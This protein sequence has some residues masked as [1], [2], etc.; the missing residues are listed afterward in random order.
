MDLVLEQRE[1]RMAIV[2]GALR[3]RSNSLFSGLQMSSRYSVLTLVI[4]GLHWYQICGV[5]VLLVSLPSCIYEGKSV[6]GLL[7]P[8]V[9]YATQ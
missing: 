5:R 8:I 4:V 2:E 7:P 9:M 1:W 3:E 6:L